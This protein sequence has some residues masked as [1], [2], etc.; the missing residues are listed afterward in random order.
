MDG[1]DHTS[2]LLASLRAL[3]P[4]DVACAVAKFPEVAQFE[5]QEEADCLSGAGLHRQC[6]FLAGRECARGALERIGFPRVPILPDTSGVPL[7]PDGALASISH[8]KGDCAAIAARASGY[9]MLGLDLEKTNRLGSSAIKRVVH[10]NEQIYV[11]DDQKRAS[12]LFSAKEAFYK[13]QFP[14]W[15]TPANFHDLELTVDEASSSLRVEWIDKRFS[16]EL[17][18]RASEIEFRFAFVADYVVSACW[19][20]GWDR[21]QR[22]EAPSTSSVQARGQ[23]G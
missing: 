10:S 20:R 22:A 1:P 23:H 17:S 2:A 21:G 5:F 8:S 18:S 11:G 13:A 16:K 15:R 9:G 14:R 19:L 4:D 3:L 6:E 12:L 7:W